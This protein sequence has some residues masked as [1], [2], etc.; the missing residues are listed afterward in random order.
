MRTQLSFTI[1]VHLVKQSKELEEE[2]FGI[3]LKDGNKF[4]IIVKT[5]GEF[6]ET[7]WH[8]FAHATQELI[9]N[10]FEDEELPTKIEDF[11]RNYLRSRKNS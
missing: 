4:T 6:Y 8:E 10:K 9:G 7:L 5:N 1:R 2:D 11:I 3:A